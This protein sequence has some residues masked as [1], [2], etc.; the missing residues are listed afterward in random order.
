MSAPPDLGDRVRRWRNLALWALLPLSAFFLLF[1]NVDL[2]SSAL[3]LD[4]SGHFPRDS[5]LWHLWRLL[6]WDSTLLL[7]FFSLV[8]LALG[9]LRGRRRARL[10]RRI[11][12]FFLLSFL[13]GPGLLANG[14]LKSWWGRAR[15]QSVTE[16]GGSQDFTPAVLIADQC[17][18]N[19]SFVSG[20][21]SGAVTLAL[22]L[23]VLILP[24]LGRRARP[25][26]AM[27]LAFVALW[28]S[29]L[30]VMTGRHFLSDTLFAADLM[31]IVVFSLF[32][33]LGLAPALQGRD[34]RE[35]LNE[36]LASLRPRR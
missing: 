32:L 9:L 6:V 33:A 18:H 11:W 31:A 2:W 36:S 21:A 35:I 24:G 34:W 13:L 14:I 8:M 25:W 29:L 1:P 23:G 16:F 17:Q 10:A 26:V 19:C 7:T 27:A 4:L 15:P 20:E 28:T 12:G 5:G 3:F 30:R 22:V